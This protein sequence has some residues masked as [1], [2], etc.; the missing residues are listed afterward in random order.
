MSTGV[1]STAG[2]TSTASET[3]VRGAEDR[4]NQGM[5]TQR[6]ATNR[7]AAGRH[8]V[9]CFRLHHFAGLGCQHSS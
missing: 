6:E 3:V 8:P 9:N 1:P 7:E 5:D 4:K 2:V